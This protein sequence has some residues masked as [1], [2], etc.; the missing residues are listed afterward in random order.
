MNRGRRL[1]SIAA[2]VLAAIALVLSVIPAYAQ[3]SATTTRRLIVK[4][5]D[6][7]ER[8]A[9]SPL[10][11]VELLAAD[12]G[13][14]LAHQRSMAFG[15]E[16]VTLFR[17][18]PVDEARGL[19]AKLATHPD[20]EFAQPDYVRQVPQDPYVGVRQPKMVPNDTFVAL[21]TYL[22]N[23]PGGINAFAA[24]DITPG[25]ASTVVAVVDS[26]ITHHV[27]LAGRTVPGYNFVSNPEIANDGDGRDPDPSDPGDWVTLADLSNP[28]FAGLDCFV[29]NSYWH[30][31]GVAGIIAANSNNGVGLAGVN[32]AAKILPVRVYGKCGDGY[33]SDALDGIAWAAGLTVPG[34]PANANPAQVINLSATADQTTSCNALWQ[35]AINQVFAHGVTR[36]FVAAAGNNRVNV[37]VVTPASC[38]DVIAVASTN[39]AGGL[40][41]YSNYGADITVSAP[42]GDPALLRQGYASA[43]AMDL[44]LTDSGTTVPVSDAYA[45]VYG[46]SFATPMVSGV[47]SLMLS[48]APNLTTAQIRSILMST[49]KPFPNHDTCSASYCGAGILDAHAAVLAALAAQVHYE[50]LWWASPAMSEAGW[51]INFAHQGDVVFASWF[52][53]D[54]SGKG[55]WLVMTA[56]NTG[57]NTFSG[58]LLTVTGPAFDAVPFDPAQVVGTP[59]GTGTL[60]FSDANNGTFAY[61]V[62]GISQTKNI[63]REVFGP[64]PTCT[65]SASNNL[66]AATNYQDLWWKKPAASESGWGI[67]LTHQGDTIF[68][69]WFTYDHDHTPMW[70]VVTATKTGPGIYSGDL[71]RT[72]GPPFSAVPFN[73][74]AVVGTKVGTASFTFSDGN[75]AAF[76]Y[77]VNGVSQTKP[78]TREVFRAPGTVCQ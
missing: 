11:R 35:Y 62:N 74:M 75:N 18:L 22:D 3:D 41:S 26:G 46:T 5:R 31:T 10:A 71:F 12:A 72:T 30:G 13:V 54:L 65:F 49:A 78:I 63:T 77:T 36:A 17:A 15:A 68:A 57:G 21:Q 60:T 44:V 34:V 64:V 58:P 73:P 67:N 24:W 42:G 51:G 47:I 8:A 7:G 43:E 52:T 23:S 19:A 48:V 4:F 9:L 53:Y 59:V 27:E 56:P 70:L 29:R 32:W 66:A 37:A 20:V 25:S 1:S 69:T 14:R 55:W 40:A 39:R 61:T 28:A 33:D 76:A 50:G 6:T 38:T 2:R 45:Y 16:V